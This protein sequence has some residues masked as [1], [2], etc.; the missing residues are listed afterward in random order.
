MTN[1]ERLS[2]AFIEAF[3]LPP[4]TVLTD[5]AYRKHPKWNSMAHMKLVSV[6]ESK[7]DIMLDSDDV[8]AMSS[9]QAVVEILKKYQIL[10]S[11]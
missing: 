1:I 9:Y 7:F 10:M 5:L 11:G 3:G 4:E 8:I 2:S 6:L